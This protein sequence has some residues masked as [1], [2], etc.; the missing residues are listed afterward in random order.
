[1]LIKSL[2]ILIIFLS[3]TNDKECI[4][5]WMQLSG[6][7]GT[8]RTITSFTSNNNYI[9]AG[10][11]T[12]GIFRSSNYG[13]DWTAVSS[14][15]SNTNVTSL[16]LKNDILIAGTSG[17]GVYISTNSG[18]NWTARNIGMTDLFINN[19]FA[20]DSIIYAGTSTESNSSG[21]VFYSINDGL[22]WN[23]TGLNNLSVKSFAANGNNLFAGTCYNGST[24][25]VFRTTNNGINWVSVSNG[26]PVY[27]LFVNSMTSSGANIY[28]GTS[29]G[30]YLTAN[31]GNN[32]TTITQA[33]PGLYTNCILLNNSNIFAG[34]QNGVYVST[35]YGTNWA[36]KNQGFVGMLTI[37]SIYIFSDFVYAGTGGHSVWRR[38]S[39]EIIGVQKLSQYIPS[40]ITLEQNYPNPFNSET[41]IRFS[42]TLDGKNEFNEQ[43]LVNLSIYDL[44]GKE[45]AVPINE[46]LQPGVYEFTLKTDNYSSSIYFYTLQGEGFRKTRKMILLK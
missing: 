21:G 12:G 17:G 29:I 44:A 45:V 35:N 14:G 20:K 32:W 31:N 28:A 5:Q 3:V 42:I 1:M 8:D 41:K 6:G 10:S 25:G 26:F 11:T 16:L 34:T 4:C 33:Y 19:L 40:S 37:Y 13:G 36:I 22:E 2:I 46:Y 9:F 23:F 18:E 7:I 24:G 30:I 15:M 43:R 39:S 38:G 27:N